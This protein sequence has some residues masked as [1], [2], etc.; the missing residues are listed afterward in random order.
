M[1][2]IMM[3]ATILFAYVVATIL[4]RGEER[5]A[6]FEGNKDIVAVLDKIPEIYENPETAIEICTIN[7]VLKHR[8]KATGCREKLTGPSAIGAFKKEMGKAFS[9]VGLSIT[10]IKKKSDRARVEYCLLTQSAEG[11][12]IESRH[13]CSA[14]MVKMGQIWKIKRMKSRTV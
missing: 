11:G 12:P 1:S 10:R 5:T 2:V 8:D 4:A 7:A 13:R 9:K 6:F 14:E 3:M